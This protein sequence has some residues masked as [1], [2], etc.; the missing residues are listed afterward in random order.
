MSL[1]SQNSPRRA[2]FSR[3]GFHPIPITHQSNM[4]DSNDATID[5]PLEN[6][7]ANGRE[8][9]IGHQSITPLR[10]ST[11]DDSPNKERRPLF[12]GRRR[13]QDPNKARTG[14]VGYDGEEDTI[15]MMGRMYKK[16]RD[17]SA[18]IRYLLYVLPV[19]AC[20]AVP[21]VIGATAA[22]HAKIGGVR[23]LW[24][25]VWVE[26]VWAS[27]WASKI[28]AHCLPNLF[29][30]FAGFV[31]SGVRKYSLVLRALEIPLSLVGWAVASLATFVPV[32]TKNPDVPNSSL[33]PWEVIVQE[34]LGAA[35]VAS[36]IYLSEKTIIQLISIDYHRKQFHFRIKESKRNIYLLS[37]LYEASRT[38]FPS[39]C[40]E[41]AEEDYTISDQL[42]TL[43]LNGKG[44]RHARSGSGT[45][46]RVLHD[47][48]RYGDKLTSAFGQVA[49][50]VTGKH[51]FDPNG[52][53][54]I[55]VQ[56]LERP[57]AAEALAKRIWTSLVVEGNEELRQDDL[58][59]VLGPDRRT[60]AEEAFAALDQDG[61][62]DISLDEMVLMVTEYARERKAIAR[63]MHD[64]DQAINVLDGLF[65]AVVLV[66]V[67]FT[68]IAFLN[69]SFVTT[70]A[71]AGTAL[72]S[73][74]FVFATTCQEVLGSSIFVFVKHPYDVG[75]RIY[76]NADQMVVEHISLLFSVFRRTNGA[77]IGRTVQIPNIVLNTLWIENIS[78]S[79]AMSEQLEID[80]DFGTTFDDVQIL[81]NELINFVTDK[82]NSRDFQPVI[83]VGI[84]G[85]SD[86][87]K[88]QLQVE[89]K[90]KSN[91]A[92]ES[93]RQARRTKFMCALVSA[94]KTVPIYPPGGGCDP[95][96][97]AAN[98][99]YNVSVSDEQAKQSVAAAAKARKD[100]R[101]V[102]T[103]KM[104]DSENTVSLT[105]S[106]RSGA[107]GLSTHDNKVVGDLASRNPAI[108]PSRDQAWTSG[109]EDDDSTL[110]ERPSIDQQEIEEVKGLLHR[111]S[112]KGKRKLYPESS[113]GLQVPSVPTI[114]EPSGVGSADYAQPSVTGY[115]ST[116]FSNS[117]SAYQPPIRNQISQ[118]SNFSARLPR[119]APTSPLDMQQMSGNATNPYGKRSD[120]A[121]RKPVGPAAGDSG[122]GEGSF[123]N[124]RPY[125]GV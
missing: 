64:V 31:S 42:A 23:I 34:I 43:G 109:R 104:T 80:V 5:I 77:N 46:M 91:W 41:F 68:F 37:L 55:V 51:I 95:Q 123:E 115:Q 105:A 25:F 26:V 113:R 1:R 112:T 93:V 6:V 24:F 107:A 122:R 30:I 84:L 117:P 110:G 47:I 98:P 90:H 12:R 118:G 36:L 39:Y 57:A 86:Q 20:I 32:M 54:S 15:N 74:S 83:E 35:T 38:L 13:Q 92:N 119:I 69:R 71:T 8:A 65:G 7:P 28:V 108:D 2:H 70:L 72:L 27:L 111:Q 99:A 63:S 102:P 11:S 16:V 66:A 56:A 121:S 59:D 120:S 82:D 73:L 45:P 87:S 33:R 96:G 49:H 94:L 10:P 76:I 50:E 52:A 106:G 124:M 9:T 114:S 75:D 88:L 3:H 125:S 89:I 40:N 116:G 53:H 61:N 4:A 21:I 78:R 19:A 100:A 60:E 44:R 62:G 85:A 67:V 79:K 29:E 48:G 97:S 18:I 101:L 17:S 22:P 81:R 58:L 14:H 103:K